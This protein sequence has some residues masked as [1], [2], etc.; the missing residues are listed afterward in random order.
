MISR[1]SL[2]NFGRVYTGVHRP[3]ISFMVAQL[4]GVA[5]TLFLIQFPLVECLI[6][7]RQEL[8]GLGQWVHNKGLVVATQSHP[9][10]RSTDRRRLL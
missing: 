9:G 5:L 1:E 2:A 10:L 4:A 3:V 6:M 8:S 7:D